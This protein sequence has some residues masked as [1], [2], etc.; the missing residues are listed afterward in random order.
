MIVNTDILRAVF[1]ASRNGANGFIR[2]PLAR[3]LIYTDGV[4][5]VAQLAGAYW[6][7]DVIGTE[8][9]PAYLKL[10]EPGLGVIKVIVKHDAAKITMD[11]DDGQPPVYIRRIEYTDFPEGTWTFYMAS[12]DGVSCTLILPTEY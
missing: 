11:V 7:L 1:D 12:D 3:N 10:E 2:H 6:L 9:V 4:R 8:F 5:D